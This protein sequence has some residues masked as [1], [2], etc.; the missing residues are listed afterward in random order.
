MESVGEISASVVDELRRKFINDSRLLEGY[1]PTTWELARWLSANEGNVDLAASQL[2]ASLEWRR[3]NDIDHLLCTD[4]WWSPP[5]VLTENH[6]GEFVGF[7]L[8]TGAPV[9][10]VPVG[11]C[12][13]KAL[14]QV[15]SSQDF[16]R[17]TLRV[18]E[19]SLALMRAQTELRD[20][21][22]E[23]GSEKA[24]VVQHVMVLDLRGLTASQVLDG[25]VLRLVV[26]LTRIHEAH[27]P[28]T[29]GAAVVVVAASGYAHT[30]CQMAISIVRRLLPSR[31]SQKIQVCI[32]NETSKCKAL[33]GTVI[34]DETVIEVILKQISMAVTVNSQSNGNSSSR[35]PRPSSAIDIGGSVPLLAKPQL[36]D[37]IM[38]RQSVGPK[39]QLGFKFYITTKDREL[40][41]RFRVVKG[42]ITFAI[43]RQRLANSTIMV[44]GSDTIERSA[45]NEDSKNTTKEEGTS[46]EPSS[47]TE[48]LSASFETM[49]GPRKIQGSKVYT[50]GRMSCEINY[51]YTLV[52]SNQNQFFPSLTVLHCIELVSR[53]CISAPYE[54][55]LEA[56]ETPKTTTKGLKK[57]P[58]IEETTVL[59]R[60]KHSTP[61]NN[62]G[63]LSRAPTTTVHKSSYT[64]K[65]RAA[66][67]E[68]LMAFVTEITNSDSLVKD[69]KHR[70]INK[71]HN[72]QKMEKSPSVKGNKK[73][74]LKKKESNPT[75]TTP[76]TEPD[77]KKA[78]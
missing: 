43:Y 75:V 29:L 6:P 7:D 34:K 78:T 32:A 42:D 59:E 28:E 67:I 53:D 54:M 25:S 5:R 39:C 23:E 26:D 24:P 45:T 62:A 38:C 19:T 47:P 36:M 3:V 56:P 69:C 64:E 10:F 57:K 70:H 1:F 13:I 58:S 48:D 76:I 35:N 50:T 30:L 46:K 17:S 15:V 73:S 72:S 31:T 71:H 16:I 37:P 41:W 51:S 40:R 33:L 66:K 44:N 68:D 4:D 77:V 2:R 60:T 9:W 63:T 11:Q 21:C 52:L 12:D 27:Y 22:D 14:L 61:V 55:F 18:L 20:V 49:E 74:L 8:V 65:E